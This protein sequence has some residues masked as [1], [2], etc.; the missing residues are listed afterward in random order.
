MFRIIKQ[1][2]LI[3]DRKFEGFYACTGLPSRDHVSNPDKI[4]ANSF[5]IVTQ[6][7]NT[8]SSVENLRVSMLAQD[9]PSRDHVSNPDKIAANSFAIVTQNKNTESSVEDLR[10]S[11]LAQ[12][13]PL[14]S[15]K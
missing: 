13:S 5:A 4:A 10:V 3:F 1:N 8:G 7:K 15:R 2:T 12:D 9:S 11:M 14:G 6:N